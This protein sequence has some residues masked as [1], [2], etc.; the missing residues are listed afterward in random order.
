MGRMGSNSGNVIREQGQTGE[1]VTENMVEWWGTGSDM[2]M[3]IENE[4]K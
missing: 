4:V 3:R 1:N 2:G